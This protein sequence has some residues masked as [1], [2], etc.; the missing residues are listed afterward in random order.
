MQ[1]MP[2]QYSRGPP[3]TNAHRGEPSL[4][5]SETDT[6]GGSSEEA[7]VIWPSRG[8][9]DSSRRSAR[10]AYFRD[11]QA[12]G[13]QKKEGVEQKIHQLYTTTLNLTI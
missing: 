8:C 12:R 9:R 13:G 6:G 10:R 2:G 1:L 7:E 4:T 5:A 11:G 3:V